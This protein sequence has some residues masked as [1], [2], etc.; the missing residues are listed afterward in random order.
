MP[1][2]N[3]E[4]VFPFRDNIISIGYVKFPLLRT[5]YFWP[6]VNV[7]KN[8]PEILPITK[9]DFFEFNCLHSDRQI[10]YKSF[11]SDFSTVWSHLP[12]CLLK[13]SLKRDFFDIYLT[14]LFIICN[15]GKRSAMRVI[16]ILKVSKILSVF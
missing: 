7:F 10:W 16:F 9:S 1:K 13:D 14:T 15:M 12:C 4:K 6:A 3:W 5:Q 8:S 2:N 11:H